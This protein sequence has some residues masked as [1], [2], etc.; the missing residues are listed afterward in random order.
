M[1]AKIHQKY[2]KN[3]KKGMPKMMPKFDA[4]N[5]RKKAILDAILIPRG[6]AGR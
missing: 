3:R 4:E 1:G 5:D 6:D 2:K